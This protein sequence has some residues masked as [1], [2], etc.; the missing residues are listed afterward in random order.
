MC[1]SAAGCLSRFNEAAGDAEIRRFGRSYA[2][3]YTSLRVFKSAES[4][5]RV[6]RRAQWGRCDADKEIRRF[7]DSEMEPR[8][9]KLAS[10]LSNASIFFER[11]S[12]RRSWPDIIELK[13]G[14][15]EGGLFGKGPDC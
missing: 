11:L 1:W 13:F 5:R 4:L 15:V 10:A 3:G 2:C 7:R 6:A 9:L 8:E 12:R 14:Q